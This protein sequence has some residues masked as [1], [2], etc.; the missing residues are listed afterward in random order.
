MRNGKRPLNK[1]PNMTEL[2]VVRQRG[3]QKTTEEEGM[4]GEKKPGTLAESVL[5]PMSPVLSDCPCRNCDKQ[6]PEGL[7]MKFHQNE[8]HRSAEIAE[9]DSSAEVESPGSSDAKLTDMETESLK[10][11]F[12]VVGSPPAG[13]SGSTKIKAVAAVAP[14]TATS[15][16]PNLEAP[17]E[18]AGS[19]SPAYSDISDDGAPVLEKAVEKTVVLSKR[20]SKETPTGGTSPMSAES[21]KAPLDSEMEKPN[22]TAK[23]SGSLA[24]GVLV[25]SPASLP[26][27]VGVPN[28]SRMPHPMFSLDPSARL[29]TAGL[30]TTHPTFSFGVNPIPSS[31]VSSSRSPGA[32]GQKSDDIRV[33]SNLNG[34]PDGVEVLNVGNSF[35]SSVQQHM[36]THHHTHGFPF[37]FGNV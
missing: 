8:H 26:S 18:R 12:K 13:G 6:F 1:L 5:E 7:A 19:T 3:K 9:M 30:L 31:F 24:T 36:H 15:D 32:T 2:G 28:M 34:A 10:Q 33:L 14:R 29:M 17:D 20:E 27:G 4:D 16:L 11:L 21:S 35:S 22:P 37:P 23:V 25:S